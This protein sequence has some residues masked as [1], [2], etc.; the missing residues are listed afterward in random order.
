MQKAADLPGLG[1]FC[2]RY[3]QREPQPS[4]GLGHSEQANSDGAQ[5]PNSGEIMI[6]K[7]LRQRTESL[8]L[9]PRE[10]TVGVRWPGASFARGGIVCMELASKSRGQPNGNRT[11]S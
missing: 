4:D 9:P 6:P 8:R 3:P 2:D 10:M 5:K 7:R 1:N 11:G